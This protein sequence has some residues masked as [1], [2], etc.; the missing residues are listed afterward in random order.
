MLLLRAA[1]ASTLR[2]FNMPE[3]A[4]PRAYCSTIE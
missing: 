3:R 2:L 1:D 4:H